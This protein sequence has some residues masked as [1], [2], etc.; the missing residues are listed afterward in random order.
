MATDSFFMGLRLREGVHLP[1]V[2]R[3]SGLDVPT[4][5]GAVIEDQVGRGLLEYSGE[6]LR[7]TPQGWWRLNSVVAALMDVD[8]ESE[9]DEEA[10]SP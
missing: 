8:S 6:Y 4:H 10:L 5:Y 7:A 1:T 9:N 3:R 2:S